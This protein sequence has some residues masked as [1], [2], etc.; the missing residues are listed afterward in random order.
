MPL[1]TLTF[2]MPNY[3]FKY[4]FVAPSAKAILVTVVVDDMKTIVGLVVLGIPLTVIKMLERL[5]E[6]SEVRSSCLPAFKVSK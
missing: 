4:Q 5:T 1:E 2:T 3:G 6:S